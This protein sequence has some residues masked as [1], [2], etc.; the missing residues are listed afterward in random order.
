MWRETLLSLP[1]Q[2]ARELAF[3]MD[4]LCG[5]FIIEL[6]YEKDR[7]WKQQFKSDIVEWHDTP[8]DPSQGPSGL[9]GDF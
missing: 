7:S 1:P 2:M 6:G 3:F 9:T 5:D 8:H 4:Q